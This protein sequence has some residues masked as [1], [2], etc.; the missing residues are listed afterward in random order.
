MGRL[1]RFRKP[2]SL[3]SIIHNVSLALGYGQHPSTTNPGSS[4]SSSSSSSSASSYAFGFP[5]AI[6]Q[7]ETLESIANISTV[8]ICA[9]S[10]SSLFAS[11]PGL[12]AVD[13][14]FTGEMS[15]HEVLA[16]TERGQCV[17]A[18]F[19]S[20]TER[21]FLS[22]RMK[23]DLEVMVE[24]EWSRLITAEKWV[25]FNDD[26]GDDEKRRRE[27]YMDVYEDKDVMVRVSERDRDPY[28]IVFARTG[29]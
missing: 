2:Q 20:N 15:H 24:D 16:A 10:G 5:L 22:Q 26:D 9:G 27:N 19:H 23:R 14:L 21:G 3:L 28:G 7:S 1:V 29:V 18:P 25:D 11:A 13:L 4:S 8:G 12:N 17:I 6:P